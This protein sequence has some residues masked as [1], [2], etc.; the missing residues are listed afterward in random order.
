[1]WRASHVQHYGSPAEKLQPPGSVAYG[2]GMFGRMRVVSGLVV[3]SGL[4]SV[5]LSRLAPGR[6]NTVSRRA[7]EIRTIES[8]TVVVVRPVTG[9][10]TRVVLCVV[11]SGIIVPTSDVSRTPVSLETLSLCGLG[12]VA[13]TD[14]GTFPSIS[15]AESLGVIRS[16]F[17][18]A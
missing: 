12:A 14:A 5:V 15:V 16:D 17:G 2:G 6:M 13:R 4:D 3:V 7:P 18:A 10:T 11:E 9:S 8:V 1:M